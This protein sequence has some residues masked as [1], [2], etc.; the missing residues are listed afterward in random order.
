MSWPTI[1]RSYNSHWPQICSLL[2]RMRISVLA[3][4]RIG[5]MMQTK[6]YRRWQTS[7]NTALIAIIVEIVY[8][9]N[10]LFECNN[11]PYFI[12]AHVPINAFHGRSCSV[13]GQDKLPTPTGVKRKSVCV[14]LGVLFLLFAMP[15]ESFFI[16]IR[17]VSLR[18]AHTLYVSIYRAVLRSLYHETALSVAGI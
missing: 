15:S 4:W 17:H 18:H 16:A 12:P 6:L 5:K 8:L 11:L 7:I 9:K 2:R 13:W 10:N 3:K 14:C 1:L